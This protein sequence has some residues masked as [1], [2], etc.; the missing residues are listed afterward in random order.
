M[1]YK[2]TLNIITETVTP[3]LCARCGAC[4]PVCP[5]HIIK[6]DEHHYPYIEE[7]DR[8]LTKCNMCVSICPGKTVDF[9]AWDDELYEKRPHPESITGIVKSCFVGY[10][11]N[12]NIREAGASGGIV[13]QLLT[14][15]LEKNLID[16][17]LVLG[18]EDDKKGYRI[19]PVIA[20]STEML[21]EA[22]R[23]KYLISP[24]LTKIQEIMETEGRYAIVALPCQTHAIRK[25]R[26]INKKFRNRVKLVIGLH[27]NTV[28]EPYLLDDMIEISGYR[29]DEV[30]NVEFR[31]GEWPGYIQLTLKNGKVVRPFKF[32][33][34][35]DAINTLKLFYSTRRCN[36]CMDFSAE[37]SDLTVADPWLRGE[38]GNY[39]YDDGWTTILT[40]TE[41]GDK[42]I[43]DATSAGYI[44]TEDLPLQTYMMNF[45]R[46]ATYKRSHVPKN[47]N[48][49]K[50]FKLPV[51]EYSR[52][53]KTFT[54]VSYLPVF[55]KISLLYISRKS[56][57]L[58]FTGVK[59]FNS[60]LAMK[61]F[62]WNR[63]RK[64]RDYRIT[65]KKTE[66]FVRRVR[67]N[68]LEEDNL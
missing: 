21:K 1:S 41:T 58:R 9:N 50:M 36:L 5:R 49:R 65:Y 35:K 20:R 45:E 14:Y 37:Y 7:M 34:I 28:Y 33:E 64:K 22:A 42:V 68:D 63:K 16:G 61:F 8:C 32:E 53:F 4:V 66:Q 17:A 62:A 43:Q 67:A 25:Y 27:C 52:P 46:N 11:T 18:S 23:S 15:M 26:K 54:L 40:R 30:S 56:K 47:I 51:P 38:D 59:L 2:K 60:D 29:R 55:V 10:S 13:T 39:L 31:G 19:N 24:H 6:L 57:F 48:M 3:G 44:I 12:K